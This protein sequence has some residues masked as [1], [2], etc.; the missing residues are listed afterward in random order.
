MLIEFKEMGKRQ[1][2]LNTFVPKPP[3]AEWEL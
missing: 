1:E 2:R 3:L